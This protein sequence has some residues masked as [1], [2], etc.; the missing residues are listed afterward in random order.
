MAVR[1]T[2]NTADAHARQS[3]VV[4][5]FGRARERCPPAVQEI[6]TIIYNY[7]TI[8]DKNEFPI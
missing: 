1:K 7:R 2:T 8:T 6:Y 5:K 4:I 3:N